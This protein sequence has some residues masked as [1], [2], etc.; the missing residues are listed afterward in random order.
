MD[1]TVIVGFNRFGGYPGASQDTCET[2]GRLA[3]NDRP[4]CPFAVTETL[5]CRAPVPF[6]HST[7]GV[8]AEYPFATHVHNR[9][10]PLPSI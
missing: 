1:I 2:A 9:T 3:A 4:A 10:P 7:G 6:T 5:K 8:V